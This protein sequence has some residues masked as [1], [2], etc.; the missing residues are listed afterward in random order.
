MG[1]TM[2]CDKK[3]DKFYCVKRSTIQKMQ[4][5]QIENLQLHKPLE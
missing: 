3:N 2:Q 5:T 1:A 4:Q